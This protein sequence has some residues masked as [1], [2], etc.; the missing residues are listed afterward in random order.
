MIALA[1]GSH[2]NSN[3]LLQMTGDKSLIFYNLT[4]P[5]SVAHF[6]KTLRTRFAITEACEYSRGFSTNGADIQ[7][8]KDGKFFLL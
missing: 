1:I 5:E 7:C 2:I 8:G 4:N 3:E 6:T